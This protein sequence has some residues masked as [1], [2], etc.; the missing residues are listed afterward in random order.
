[1]L[2]PSGQGCPVEETNQ[3]SRKTNVRRPKLMWYFPKHHLVDIS[4]EY[5]PPKVDLRS[6]GTQKHDQNEKFDK[7]MNLST[8]LLFS[9]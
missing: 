7:Q 3:M 1:M 4:L 9:L 6:E 2:L 8:I 5:K